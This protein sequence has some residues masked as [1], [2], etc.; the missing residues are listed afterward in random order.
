MSI[1]AILSLF[2]ILAYFK[3]VVSAPG[4]CHGLGRASWDLCLRMYRMHI[5]YIYIYTPTYTYIHIHIYIY[6]YNYSNQ[7]RFSRCSR[8][9]SPRQSA[10]ATGGRLSPE[11]AAY[12]LFSATASTSSSLVSGS[13]SLVSIHLIL[14][15]LHLILAHLPHPRSSRSS[16][17]HLAT[18]AALSPHPL[19]RPRPYAAKIAPCALMRLGALGRLR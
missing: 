18:A 6:I 12:P 1:F 11:K 3:R 15:R 13:S 9:H 2:S 16:S 10:Q 7:I 19:P 14:A 5:I 8:T 17:Q 4:A